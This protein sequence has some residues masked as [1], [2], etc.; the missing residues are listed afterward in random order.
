M[1]F[2]KLYMGDY[3]RDTGALSI[4]EHGAYFLML[5]YHYAT[6]KPLPKGKDLYRLIRCESKADRE[7]VDAVAR[8]YWK[9]TPEGLVNDR[10]EREIAIAQ[11]TEGG[12]E[13]RK[14]NERERQ[15]RHRER[16]K[17][18]Y[19]ALRAK[20][21]TPSFDAT[22]EELNALLNGDDNATVTRDTTANHS[23][24]PEPKPRKSRTL[25]GKPDAIEVLKFLNLKANRNYEPVPANLE[26]IQAR[27]AEGFTLAQLRQVVAKKCREWLADDKM[28]E[29]LRPKTLF[30]RTNFANYAGELVDAAEPS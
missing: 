28:A 11:E 20:G 10:A 9:E 17:Q 30:S 2:F 22:T 15:K 13:E 5:Q 3:Q 12:A 4:A 8:L 16:R 24:T 29:Y 25:S 27:L 19:D 21:I 7:A 18:L 1:N 23:Q 6:E 26:M 14:K